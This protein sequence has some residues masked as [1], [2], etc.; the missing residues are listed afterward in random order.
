MG[1]DVGGQT[2]LIVNIRNNTFP[3]RVNLVNSETVLTPSPF[4]F[5]NCNLQ[6]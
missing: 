3:T 4:F 2:H 1:I 5:F 6:M